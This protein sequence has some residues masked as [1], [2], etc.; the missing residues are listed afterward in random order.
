MYPLKEYSDLLKLLKDDEMSREDIY[1]ELINKEKEVLDVVSRVASQDSHTKVSKELF[2]N[3]TFTEAIAR[4]ANVWTNIF[5]ETVE[6]ASTG[7]MHNLHPS[8]LLLKGDRKI[9]VG[10]MLVIIALMMFFISIT[11]H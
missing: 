2:P 4:F 11:Q 3:L 1:Q 8:T 5:T 7:R 9:Y 10:A 6:N